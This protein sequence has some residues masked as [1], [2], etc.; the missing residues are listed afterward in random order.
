MRR[1]K[2]EGDWSVID[3]VPLFSDD[4]PALEDCMQSVVQHPMSNE[5]GPASSASR[6][7]RVPLLTRAPQRERSP[8]ITISIER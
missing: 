3:A 1:N 2:R 6:R 7:I 5:R 4:F 8:T